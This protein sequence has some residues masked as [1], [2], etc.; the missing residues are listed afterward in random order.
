MAEHGVEDHGHEKPVDHEGL[1]LPALGHGAGDDSRRR[2][3]EDHLEEEEQEDAHIVD[4][5]AG[6]GEPFEPEE[7]PSPGYLDFGVQDLGTAQ[8]GDGP[9]A[10]EHERIPDQEIADHA[11]GEDGE[12]GHHD[13]HGIALLGETRLHHGEPRLHEEDQDSP[14]EHPHEVDGYAVVPDLIGQVRIPQVLA[15]AGIAAGGV[16]RGPGCPAENQEE[17]EAEHHSHHQ[18]P[19]SA[20]TRAH[21]ATSFSVASSIS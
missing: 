19:P 6:E 1:E 16:G 3:H 15:A 10:A 4:P 2:I 17:R 14:Q 12:V 20:Q 18:R 11:D 9:H 21:I 7:R 5:A 8:G 13:V